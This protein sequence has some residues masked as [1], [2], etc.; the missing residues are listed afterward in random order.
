MGSLPLPPS[1]RPYPSLEAAAMALHVAEA[2]CS[3]STRARGAAA[4]FAAGGVPALRETLWRALSARD[5]AVQEAACWSM[6]GLVHEEAHLR[7]LA[8][9]AEGCE[10]VLAAALEVHGRAG[11]RGCSGR[12]GA[13]PD[14][15]T[16]S[17]GADE[18]G[19]DTPARIAQHASALLDLMHRRHRHG[20][21][22]V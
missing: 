4:L 2:V 18:D 17:R 10:G 11:V 6:R 7:A 13:D 20:L 19:E 1:P 9:A 16:G 15:D 12:P 22:A 14:D 3:I 5:V 21:E 8:D